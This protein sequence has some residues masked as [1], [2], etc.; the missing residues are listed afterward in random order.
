M[1]IA[2]AAAVPFLPSPVVAEAGEAGSF[3]P[4]AD[5]AEAGPLLPSAVVAEAMS[6]LP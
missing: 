1:V 2:G 3:L 4:T 5:V 6:F